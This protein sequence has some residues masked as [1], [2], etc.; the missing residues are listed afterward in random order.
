MHNVHHL[1]SLMKAARHSIIDD[2]FEQFVHDFFARYYGG[3]QV[4]IWAVNALAI[5][6]IRLDQQSSVS[7]NTNLRRSAH[8]V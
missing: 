6:G 3:K 1:L 8:R 7:Y 5:V 2:R 4:P